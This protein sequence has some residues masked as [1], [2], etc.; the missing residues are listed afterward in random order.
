MTRE[1]LL[2]EPWGVG[3]TANYVDYLAAAL[4]RRAPSDGRIVLLAADDFAYE[5]K[6]CDVLPVLPTSGGGGGSSNKVVNGLRLARRALMAQEMIV[7]ELKRR[8]PSILHLSGATLATG[9]VLATAR[10]LA[11][12]V[13]TAIH[14]LPQK[15]LSPANLLWLQWRPYFLRSDA[16]VVHGPWAAAALPAQY[17]ECRRP[18]DVIRYGP[19]SFGQPTERAPQRLRQDAGLPGD[20]VVLLFFGSLRRDKGLSLL[21]HALS[22]DDERR[23]HLHVVGNRPAVSEP[24]VEAYVHEAEGL[25]IASSITWRIGYAPD[26]D[27]P[28]IFATADLVVLPYGPSYAAYSAVLAMAVAYERPVVATDVGD[29][30]RAVTEFDLGVVAADGSPEKL[31]EALRAAADSADGYRASLHAFGARF[32]WDAMA[33]ETW[34]LYTRSIGRG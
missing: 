30:G 22:L 14:D 10:R 8:R 27:V 26:G 24:P 32:S 17:P 15:G 5:P 6:G 2:V 25:G 4:A 9:R 23:F 31:L 13:I 18:P 33:D 29:T 1:V 21:L 28:D 16:I 7:R 12:P 20:K 34:A 19:F 3:G 11:I